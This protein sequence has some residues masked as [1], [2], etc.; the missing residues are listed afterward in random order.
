MLGQTRVMLLHPVPHAYGLTALDGYLY[1]TDWQTRNVE[2]M[3][4][5]DPEHVSPVRENMPSMMGI[6]AVDMN[7]TTNNV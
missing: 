1:W 5:H 3:N 6:K 2:R 7:V 4:L